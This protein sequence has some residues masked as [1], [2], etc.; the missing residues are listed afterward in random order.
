MSLDTVFHNAAKTVFNVFKSIIHKVEFVRVTDDGFDEEKTEKFQVDMI[1][2]SFDAKDVELLGF[3]RLIQPTDVKG[4]FRG[5][6]LVGFTPTTTDI[7]VDGDTT[8][9]VVATQTDPAQALWILL[10]RNT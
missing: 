6:Q 1:V 8:Y 5:K 4:M 10:L 7:V 3:N 2:S 9:S